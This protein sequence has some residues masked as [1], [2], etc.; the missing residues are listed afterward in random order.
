MRNLL[1]RKHFIGI[2]IFSAAKALLHFFIHLQGKDLK[3]SA[4]AASVC[5]RSSEHRKRNVRKRDYFIQ[6]TIYC[7]FF[8]LAGRQRKFLL[9]RKEF[10]AHKIFKNNLN[11]QVMI[12]AA[13]YGLTSL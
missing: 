1:Q 10:H 13:F 2:L 7:S 5:Y 9:S 4:A 8:V 3:S 11:A 6:R 12:A